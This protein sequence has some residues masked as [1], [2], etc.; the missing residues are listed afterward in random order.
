MEDQIK[1]NKARLLQRLD[2]LA[3]IGALDDGGDAPPFSGGVSRL[4]LSDADKEARDLTVS[5]MEAL[6]LKVSI[7]Q[8]GNFF[9]IRPGAEDLPPVL[10]GSHIDSVTVAGRYDGSYGV[11]AALEALH[12]L[13]DSQITTHRPLGVAAFTN[14]EGASPAVRR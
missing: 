7:D 6:E 10:L 14:E 1:I 9:A 3:Q 13:H 12:T 8:V 5:W 11:L 4:A 2:E